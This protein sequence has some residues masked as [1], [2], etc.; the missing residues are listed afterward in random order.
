MAVR[1]KGGRYIELIQIYQNRNLERERD[2]YLLHSL[3]LCCRAHSAH[4]Q[5]HIDGWSY[6][7]VEELSL[8]EDLTVSDGDDI[9]RDVG[10]HITGLGLNDRQGGQ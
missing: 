9:G 7:F 3:D 4:R 10:G 8:K 5:T 2:L 1:W 6:T